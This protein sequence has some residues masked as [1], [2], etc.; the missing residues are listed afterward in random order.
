MV[1]DRSGA[2]IENTLSNR[3]NNRLFS[4]DYP[5]API[6]NIKKILVKRKKEKYRPNAVAA[7]GTIS[8]ICMRQ[9]ACRTPKPSVPCAHRHMERDNRVVA[10]PD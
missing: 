10:L 9:Q 6:N 1:I 8:R 3:Q 2:S 4:A 5:C 7:M